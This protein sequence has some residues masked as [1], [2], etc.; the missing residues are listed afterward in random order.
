MNSRGSNLEALIEDS[1]K[2]DGPGAVPQEATVGDG[3]V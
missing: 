3:E 2:V 1:G